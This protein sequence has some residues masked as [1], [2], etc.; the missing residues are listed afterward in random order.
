MFSKSIKISRPIFPNRRKNKTMNVAKLIE[1]LRSISGRGDLAEYND[2]RYAILQTMITCL[3]EKIGWHHVRSILDCFDGGMKGIVLDM[4]LACFEGRPISVLWRHPNSSLFLK[5]G[6]LG[7]PEE[8]LKADQLFEILTAFAGK[9]SQ[10][11]AL[12]TL[13][14]S[15]ILLEELTIAEV[16]QILGL[17]VGSDDKSILHTE[18]AIIFL[19][20]H[21][22]EA[23]LRALLKKEQYAQL[24]A[25]HNE[26]IANGANPDLVAYLRNA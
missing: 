23:D 15:K 21:M 7:Y 26:V 20:K 6:F 12:V 25:W 3:N 1:T 8:K 14:N 13:H 2:C 18:A 10:K 16:E 17:F 19:G 24:F 9:R 11:S 5:Q 22:A 4:L